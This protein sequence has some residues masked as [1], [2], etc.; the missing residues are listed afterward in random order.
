VVLIV[1]LDVVPVGDVLLLVDPEVVL[2]PVLVVASDD[3]YMEL[4]VTPFC[5]SSIVIAL[6]IV[7][8]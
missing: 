6:G 3:E 2:P 1:V 5:T 7:A 4:T 8:G